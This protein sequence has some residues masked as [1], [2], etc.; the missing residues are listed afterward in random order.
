MEEGTEPGDQ[1]KR[2]G[3]SPD[4]S[5]QPTSVSQPGLQPAA[6]TLTIRRSRMKKD[7][8]VSIKTAAESLS[9][10]A[11]INIE[12]SEIEGALVFSMDGQSLGDQEVYE[13]ETVEETTRTVSESEYGQTEDG[14]ESQAES[15]NEQS[16]ARS[17][18]EEGQA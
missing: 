12:R 10:A 11:T 16:Q 6:F 14:D 1:L 7:V 2:G 13:A 17:G 5:I 15:V 4:S 18:R 9:G 8:E 3:G